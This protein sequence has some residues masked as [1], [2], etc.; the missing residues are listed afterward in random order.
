MRVT[1]VDTARLGGS[2]ACVRIETDEGV[3]G[4]G[5]ASSE[6]APRAVHA[7]VERYAEEYL[8][9]A[10]PTPIEKHRR[11]LEDASWFDGVV[12]RSAIT[13][14]EHAL[15]DVKARSLGVPVYE[16]LGG[17]VRDEVRIY[18]WI[19]V[20]SRA[21][22]A[23]QAERL[24]DD[25]LSA[26]KFC[27]TPPEPSSYPQVVDEAVETVR[28]V[29]EAVGPDVDLMLDPANRWKLAEARHLLSELEAFDPLFAEDFVH[30]KP[31]STVEKLADSTTIPYALG[32]RLFGYGE[33]EPLITRDAAAVLQPD[34]AHAGGFLQMKAIAAAAEHH[35]IRLAPHNALG[36]LATAAAVHFALS[37]PNFLIQEIAGIDFYQTWEL[38]EHV[39]MDVL[40]VE[41]GVI[42]KPEEPG[43]GVT[44]ADEVFEREFDYSKPPLFVDRDEF[45]TPEW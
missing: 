7:Y 32:D 42:P 34:I 10:D 38:A 35:G 12:V 1:S 31:V 17:P 44:V 8:L 23:A 45:H 29:R 2:S 15:W 37:I 43:L 13:A 28:E 25:G 22:L 33:F 5:E 4:F 40:D 30:P 6:Q 20:E 24:V 41:D 14:V 19:G 39:E 9:G 16:L 27:P 3:T 11:R 18:R 21:D 36:P 26:T